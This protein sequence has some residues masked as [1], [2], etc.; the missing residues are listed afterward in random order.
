MRAMRLKP[1]SRIGIEM[2]GLV[3]PK[4]I[5][6][7]R[8][9]GGDAGKVTAFLAFEWMK[10]SLR[11]FFRALFQDKIDLVCLGRPNTEVC[12]GRTN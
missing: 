8:D 5:K 2:L 6:R 7:F 11:V 1:G 12:F 9:G 4:A 3:Y 10:C